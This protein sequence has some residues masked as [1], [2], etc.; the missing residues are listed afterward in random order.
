MG[1]QQ[2][3]AGGGGGKDKV[4]LNSQIFVKSWSRVLLRYR[5]LIFMKIC[6]AGWQD[7]EEEVWAARPHQGRQEEEEGQGEII[8]EDRLGFL[9][10]PV[11]TSGENIE[12]KSFPLQNCYDP[13]LLLD[14]WSAIFLGE[15]LCTV[16]CSR[17]LALYCTWFHKVFRFRIDFGRLDPV[18]D[19]ERQRWRT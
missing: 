10:Y 6:Y 15:S 8:F 4:R 14:C 19:P 7:W 3:G 9:K 13:H 12:R 1:N 16:I 18:P 11:C 2:S 17:Q 5:Y